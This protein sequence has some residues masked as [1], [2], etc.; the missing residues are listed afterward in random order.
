MAAKPIVEPVDRGPLPRFV[1]SLIEGVVLIDPDG[2][3]RW[4]TAAA[5]ALHGCAHRAP[6]RGEPVRQARRESAPRWYGGRERELA[7]Y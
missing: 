5:L 4:A 7:A 1:G 6:P 2:S 3:I